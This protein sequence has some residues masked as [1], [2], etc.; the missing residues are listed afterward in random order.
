MPVA[1]RVMRRA[2][3]RA[4]VWLGTKIFPDRRVFQ[5][6]IVQEMLQSW[7]F[8]QTNDAEM[9]QH[10]L[11]LDAIRSA[12]RLIKDDPQ[13]SFLQFR[14][15]A[16]R[17]SAWSMFRA[18]WAYQTGYGVAANQLQAEHWYRLSF[19]GGCQQAQLR[20]G[21]IY[22]RRREFEQC[23]KIYEVDA[24]KNWAPALYYLAWAKL[25]QP[26]TPERL[27]AARILLEQA[28]A[29]GDVG[30]EVDLAVLMSRGRFGLLLVPRGFHILFDAVSKLET[31][32]N[33]NAAIPNS[34]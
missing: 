18:G 10:D 17:G 14:A 7:R 8:S 12:E 28:A 27:K 30:A 34:T 4:S 20:L 13:A 23:E 19:E 24:H 21:S 9:Y 3:S 25:R 2:L 6:D 16:E 5:N 15:L 33:E 1:E 31:F 11:E 22:T 32:V 26:K 29:R